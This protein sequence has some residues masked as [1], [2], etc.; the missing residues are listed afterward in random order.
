MGSQAGSVGLGEVLDLGG[1]R[2]W[3]WGEQGELRSQGAE[4]PVFASGV[5]ISFA[6]AVHTR[7][8]LLS[9]HC[10]SCWVLCDFSSLRPAL[11]QGKVEGSEGNC[12]G[13]LGLEEPGSQ[14]WASGQGLVLCSQPCLC[15]AAPTPLTVSLPNTRPYSAVWQGPYGT[16]PQG[17][18]VQLLHVTGGD[19]EAQRLAPNPTIKE[20]ASSTRGCL[21]V[22]CKRVPLSEL[23][24][25]LPRSLLPATLRSQCSPQSEAWLGAGFQ[26]K[27]RRA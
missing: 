10:S 27:G 18:D 9:L 2:E 17:C 3:T 26:G 19:T 8:G 25:I 7:P 20:P 23:P 4:A 24:P 14:L 21:Q 15:R 22:W 5:C 12:L 11:L 13:R 16:D 1:S 6:C